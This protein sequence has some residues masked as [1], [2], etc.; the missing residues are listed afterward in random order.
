MHWIDRW[1]EHWL[2]WIFP[3]RCVAC[4][5]YGG[6]LCKAC[7]QTLEYYDEP[8]PTLL[9]V[10]QATHV[11]YVYN[12]TMRQIVHRLKYRRERRVARLAG[13]LIAQR[14]PTCLTSASVFV[15]VPLHAT[16][17][18]SRGFNQAALLA[19]ALA[20][21]SRGQLLDQLVR[22]RD[23]PPQARLGVRERQANVAD[24]FVWQGDPPPAHVILVDDVL[25][26][27]ATMRACS[28]ALQAAGAR[29]ITGLALA[30]SRA[31]RQPPPHG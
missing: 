4:E 31:P 2:A 16:R 1:C 27:G 29:T 24:A 28:D 10:Q 30:R 25:T 5:R 15:P 6:S 14:V 18:A 9:A 17:L 19:N 13:H 20:R 22:Q 7:Q 12:H 23:T 26:T 11:A 21:L 8:P 3:E